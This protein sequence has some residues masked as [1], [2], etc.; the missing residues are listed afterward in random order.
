M[1][2]VTTISEMRATVLMSVVNQMT[3]ITYN[4]TVFM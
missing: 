2:E 4:K 3:D 1:G